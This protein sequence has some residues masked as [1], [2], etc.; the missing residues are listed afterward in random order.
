MLSKEHWGFREKARLREGLEGYRAT[1]SNRCIGKNRKLEVRLGGIYALEGIANESKELHW[2]IME[3][4]CTYVRVN[5]SNQKGESSQRRAEIE[6]R[7]ST[8]SRRYSG[9]PHGSWQTRS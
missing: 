7:I 6:E 4:L 8:P 9:Y 3:V 2:P 1:W 5:P